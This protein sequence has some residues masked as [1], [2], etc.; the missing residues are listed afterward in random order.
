MRSLLPKQVNIMALTATAT[1]KR[2]QVVMS[3]LAMEESMKVVSV[4]PDKPNIVY[5]VSELTTFDQVLGSICEFLQT[6]TCGWMII[7]CSTIQDCSDI[8]CAY[9]THIPQTHLHDVQT[10]MYK[11]IKHGLV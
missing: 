3:L 11:S 2:C 10:Y 6:Q 5:S 1:N 7:F 9:I 4:C 8:T